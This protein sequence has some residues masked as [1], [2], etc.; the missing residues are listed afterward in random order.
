MQAWRRYC[1]RVRGLVGVGYRWH[2]S[3]KTGSVIK[4]MTS[5]DAAGREQQ[6][7]QGAAGKD[8]LNPCSQHG[9]PDCLCQ[10]LARRHKSRAERRTDALRTAAPP[11][12]AP[13][14]RCTSAI[15]SSGL[16][17]PSLVRSISLN[18]YRWTAGQ[19]RQLGRRGEEG[20]QTMGLGMG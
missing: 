6:H 13:G 11:S 20:E 4:E 3:V 1:S 8:W 18:V 14:L 12:P 9:C 5:A 10:V 19:R 16:I 7:R 15:H 17:T 2:T